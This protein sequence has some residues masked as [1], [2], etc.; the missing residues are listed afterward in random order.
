MDTTEKRA[1]GE[2]GFLIRGAGGEFWFRV[3]DSEHNF[4]DYE[5]TNYDCEVVIIDP[6]AA[7]IRNEAGDFLDYTTES[8]QPAK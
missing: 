6:D 2:R 4:V 1:I 7:L 8:M 5:I 3:Y